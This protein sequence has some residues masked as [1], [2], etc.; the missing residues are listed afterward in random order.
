MSNIINRL[1][2]NRFDSVTLQRI[3]VARSIIRSHSDMSGDNDLLTE[4]EAANLFGLAPVTLR[5]WRSQRRGPAPVKIGRKSFYR[6]ETL[7][8]WIVSR[9]GTVQA[10]CQNSDRVQWGA[11]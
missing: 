7:M 10:E 1:R 5:N 8:K 9:E 11:K 6:R 4:R 3:S 2:G